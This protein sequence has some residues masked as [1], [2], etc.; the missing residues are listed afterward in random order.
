MEQ[1]IISATVT[2]TKILKSLILTSVQKPFSVCEAGGKS[3]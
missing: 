1:L 3:S 2:A